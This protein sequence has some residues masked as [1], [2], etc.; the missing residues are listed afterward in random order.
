MLRL[1]PA[2]VSCWWPADYK[3]SLQGKEGE[4]R[5]NAM[6]ACHSRGAWQLQKLCFAN[7]GIYIKLGQHVAQLDHLL[8]PEYVHTMRDHMLDKCPVSSPAEVAKTLREDL[9]A[10]PEEL[11][12]SFEDTPIASASLAQVH[13]AVSHD[14]Q[15]LAVKVQHTG[16]RDTCQADTLVVEVFVRA[17]RWAF[18]DFNYQWLIDEVKESLPQEL[19]F[20]LEAANL[21]RCQAHLLHPRSKVRG[22]V[23][24]P[25]L[26]QGML[27][28]RVLAME[29]VEG[30][31]VTDRQRLQEAGLRPQAIAQL[32]SQTFNEMIFLHGYVHCDPH[33]ANL[34]VRV[35]KGRPQLILLDHGLYR[36]ITD[37]FRHDYAC[38]WQA[39]IFS[40][41]EGIKKYSAAMNAGDMYPLFAGMLTQRP[42]D[43]VTRRSWDHLN[44]KRDDAERE[45]IMSTS[46]QFAK[47]IS[48]LLQRVPRALLLLLKTNDCLRAID[49]ALG[50]PVNTFVIT[51][52]ECTRALADMKR[53]EGKGL[54]SQLSA[55][56]ME[57]HV[58][59][60][61]TLLKA[62]TWLAYL[63]A[64]WSGPSQQQRALA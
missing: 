33:A 60:R 43:Q 26:Q 38:L 49:V 44:L 12:R 3:F 32:V 58:E 40:D 4:E 47:E 30:I 36:S 29:F 22:Q 57:W 16:L 35:H 18:P 48:A 19:D 56:W 9:G 7:G 25:R 6:N 51:A 17:L 46:Q 8:P 2:E 34:F 13:R 5:Q 24:V 37:Q 45:M 62:A 41:V 21:L 53:K 39:L 20:E 1:V 61:V 23:V 31:K 11:F 59:W 27:S 63:K 14:G 28:K 15:Q 10:G 42:W 54:R 64:Y 55:S 50:Q 52:R